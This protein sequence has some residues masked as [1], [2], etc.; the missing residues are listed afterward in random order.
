MEREVRIE[1]TGPMAS[2]KTTTAAIIAK[3]LRGLGVE[4]LYEDD[5]Q[6]VERTIDEL[7]PKS[8]RPMRIILSSISYKPGEKVDPVMAKNSNQG[9]PKD[10]RVN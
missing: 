8:L 9:V 5:G 6:F 4:V 2:G 1:I 10:R 3:T 7:D